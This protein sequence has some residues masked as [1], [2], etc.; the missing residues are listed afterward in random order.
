LELQ[1]RRILE[2]IPID[3]P[4]QD[5]SHLE[6]KWVSAELWDAFLRF[7][8]SIVAR[9]LHDQLPTGDSNDQ[10]PV[11]ALDGSVETRLLERI[12]FTGIFDRQYRI[13]TPFPETFS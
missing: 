6:G 3:Q 9:I 1:K 10:T 5:R 12:K 4:P 2:A 13:S 7:D 11:P 8:E